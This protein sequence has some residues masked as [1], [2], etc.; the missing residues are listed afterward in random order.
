M[1]AL[2]LHVNFNEKYCES[3]A[4]SVGA[5]HFFSRIKSNYALSLAF[6]LRFYA[7]LIFS[8]FF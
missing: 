1:G 8:G 7:I 3:S 6:R 2:F 4:N 5:M